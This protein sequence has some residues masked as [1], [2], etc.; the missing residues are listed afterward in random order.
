MEG[1]WQADK[2]KLELTAEGEGGADNDDYAD[3]DG[4]NGEDF[5]DD[6]EKVF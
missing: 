6:T 3:D 1:K 4:D 5:A 2:L